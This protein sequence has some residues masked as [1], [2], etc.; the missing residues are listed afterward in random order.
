MLKKKL[1][2]N[3]GIIL[4]LSTNVPF[5]EKPGSS[6]L[7]ANS[8]KKMC[9]RVKFEVKMQDNKLHFYLKCHFHRCFLLILLV[10]QLPSFSI[11]GTFTWNGLSIYLFMFKALD[12][13]D[14]VTWNLF[15]FMWNANACFT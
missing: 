14:I 7:L 10:N 3:D 1:I 11:S 6:F 2:F 13:V 4:I 9:G 5:M 8:V 15:P 12:L